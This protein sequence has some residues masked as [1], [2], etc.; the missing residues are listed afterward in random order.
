G[1]T[2]GKL[3]FNTTDECFYLNQ[4]V[5]KICPYL[6]NPNYLYFP[7]TT[8]IAENL[9]KSLG[10]AIPNLSTAQ[11]NDIVFALPPLSEQHRIVAKV[12]DLMAFCD[13]LEQTQS[14]NIAAH[15]QLVEALLA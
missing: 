4:R 12:D 14:D 8:K 1:A 5:G 7:L 10:S 3:G 9:E 11:I 15:A 13:Q 2:T 6:I